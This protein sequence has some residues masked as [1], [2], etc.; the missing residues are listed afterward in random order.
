MPSNCLAAQQQQV[1]S[2]FDM[3]LVEI[4]PLKKRNSGRYDRKDTLH[5]KEFTQREKYLSYSYVRCIRNVNSVRSRSRSRS[6]SML[7]LH[8]WYGPKSSCSPA[9]FLFLGGLLPNNDLDSQHLASCSAAD[10]SS[11]STLAC[12]KTAWEL[13]GCRSCGRLAISRE[14]G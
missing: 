8:S 12:L 6:R 13:Q 9:G 14:G 1:T 4:L 11:S 2:M 5:T 3:R 10:W 7:V